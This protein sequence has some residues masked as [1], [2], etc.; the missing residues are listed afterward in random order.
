MIEVDLTA[1]TP[2]LEDLVNR[3]GAELTRRRTLDDAEA[4]LAAIQ[5]SVDAALGRENREAWV[6]P[7]GAVDAYRVGAHVTHDGTVWVSLAP[8]N[9]WEPPVGWREVVEGGIA[10]WRQ[11]VGAVDAYPLGEV[12][13]HKGQEWESQVA[14]NVWEP[15]V[16]G[17]REKPA[18]TEPAIA[19]WRQPT[20]GHDAYK[21]GDQVT[22]QGKTFESLIDANVWSPTAYPQ[23]W[24]AL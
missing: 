21:K 16:S 6:Q 10:A 19:E 8:F 22:F 12:V 13:S 7:S 18:T 23:G 15:G 17:W 1:P 20:G 5:E 9:V 2:D 4:Q 14:A 3:V 11:P 24:K